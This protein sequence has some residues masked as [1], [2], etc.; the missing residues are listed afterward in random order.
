MQIPK[1]KESFRPVADIVHQ[2]MNSF[3]LAAAVDMKVFDHLDKK[4]VSFSVVAQLIAATAN[5]TEALLDC[6]VAM[7]LVVKE[8][9]EYLNTK[10]ASEYLVSTAPAYQGPYVEMTTG[11]NIKMLQNIPELI[12][13]TGNPER[14]DS[15]EWLSVHT[16]KMLGTTSLHGSLQNAVAFIKVLPGFSEFEKMCDVGGNHGFYSMGL[17]DENPRLQAVVC[18][19]PG[20]LKQAANVHT[21]MGYGESISVRSVDLESDDLLGTDYD[22][23]LASHVLYDWSGTLLSVV[24]KIA[25]S[26]KS[27][28]YFVSNHMYKDEGMPPSLSAS[29]LE[30]TTR[31]AGYSGHHISEA[32]L[33]EVLTT[34]GFGDFVV[35]ESD[36]TRCLLLAARKI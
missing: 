16:V 33:R 7:G 32:E 26:L 25:G 22:L 27:G 6:L 13:N 4:A 21:E 19:L 5:R 3:I 23:V 10:V 35:S 36:E 2:G 14:W 17:I 8:S 15:E 18:D 11:F 28:G 20:L 34:A 30:L 29:V 31:L 9:N 12:K 24:E 1:L